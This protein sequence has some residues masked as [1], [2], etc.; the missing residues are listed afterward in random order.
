MTTHE[1]NERLVVDAARGRDDEALGPVVPTVEAQHLRPR[2]AGD[3]RLRPEDRSA[4]RVVGPERLL[5]QVVDELVRRV[6]VHVDLLEDHL[7]LG[8]EVRGSQGAVAEHVGEVRDGHHVKVD[9]S[10]GE[11]EGVMVFEILESKKH[12]DAS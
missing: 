12:A 9:V 2:G 8:L 4:E 3:A 11:H 10:T 1:P 7:A 5:E 6:L